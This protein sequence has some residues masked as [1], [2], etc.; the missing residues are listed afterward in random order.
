LNRAALAPTHPGS[1][2]HQ[3][4]ILTTAMAM[5][6]GIAS[7]SPSHPE[8]VPLFPA[9][10]T[11]LYE[12]QPAAGVE[13]RFYPDPPRADGLTPVARTLEDGTFALTTYEEGDGAPP[14]HYSVGLRWPKIDPKIPS[15]PK[16]DRL[17]EQYRDSARTSW[18][19]TIAEAK[20]TLNM[21][22]I[23]AGGDPKAPPRKGTTG[24]SKSSK[25][26]DGPRS[27]SETR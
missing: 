11:V 23:P 3:G 10:G 21:I 5:V 14:G 18:R 8:R 27:R 12:G 6:V 1:G 2:T 25:S 26:H 4:L 22:R 7:C 13:L 24:R 16:L 20:N 17:N 9:T 19:V 15:G